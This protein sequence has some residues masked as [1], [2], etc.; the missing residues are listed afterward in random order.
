MRGRNV[1]SSLIKFCSRPC[2]FIFGDAMPTPSFRRICAIKDTINPS[3][4]AL[5]VISLG[6]VAAVYL[7]NQHHRFRLVH[8]GGRVPRRDAD[9]GDALLGY[10]VLGARV[11]LD[12]DLAVLG[13]LGKGN[14]RG[15]YAA[16]DQKRQRT[17]RRNG[18][19]ERTSTSAIRQ[20]CIHETF[21]KV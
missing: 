9:P 20:I 1:P 4:L 3:C 21:Q 5:H 7:R 13:P 19:A 10:H 15:Q 14:G 18:H 17:H 11:H 2:S 16:S 12:A 8:C 6:G